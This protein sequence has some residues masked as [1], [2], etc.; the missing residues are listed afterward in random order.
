MYRLDNDMIIHC[1]AHQG[2][3]YAFLGVEPQIASMRLSP[4]APYSHKFVRIETVENE[5]EIMEEQSSSPH[6][7]KAFTVSHLFDLDCDPLR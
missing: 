2:F 3:I 6:D 4:I 5:Q 1:T 7:N